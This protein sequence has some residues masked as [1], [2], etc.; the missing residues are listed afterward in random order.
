MEDLRYP[1]KRIGD[2]DDYFKMSIVEYKAPGL[3]FQGEGFA[4]GT[5][6]QS[7]QKSKA[8]ATIILPMPANI[9]D[10]N[11]ASWTEGTMNPVQAA[12]G[13]AGYSG[14]LSNNLFGSIGQSITEGFSKIDAAHSKWS[15]T[16]SNGRYCRWCRITS[17][18]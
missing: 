15:R 9:Q 7:L 18:H 1:I 11:A 16:K 17:L 14:V 2:Q 8:I 12:L 10:N 6:E 5:T 13:S 3:G 4:L